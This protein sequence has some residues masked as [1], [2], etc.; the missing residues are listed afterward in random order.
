MS[1]YIEFSLRVSV[2]YVVRGGFCL[3][4]VHRVGGTAGVG[5][6]AFARGAAWDA[7]EVGSSMWR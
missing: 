2:S 4:G 3:F 6:F 7:L 5:G 1:G